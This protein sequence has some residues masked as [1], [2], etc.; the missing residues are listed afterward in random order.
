MHQGG[1]GNSAHNGP[2]FVSWHRYYLV[3]FE[4]ALREK[5]SR[6][7]L[8][9]W[10]ST[11]DYLMDNQKDSILFTEIFLGNPKG[12][13]YSGP[14]A[15]WE[16]PTIPSTLL[17]RD[18]GRFGSPIDPQRLETVFSKKY[19]REIL[20]K[21]TPDSSYANLESHHDN[22]HG[23][24]G[25]DDGHMSDV[26]LS[27][28]D[29]VFWLHH[30]FVDYLW[31]KFRKRQKILGINSE[32]DYP[33]TTIPEHKPNRLM[34]N[35]RPSKKNIQ[36][37]SNSFTK[38]IYR[39][40]PAPTCR[41]NCGGAFKGFLLCDRS[42]K[43]CVSGSRYDFIRNGGLSRVKSFY[44]SKAKGKRMDIPLS[45]KNIKSSDQPTMV[46]DSIKAEGGLPDIK[47][48][49]ISP[50]ERTENSQLTRTST[51][52]TITQR[53]KMHFGSGRSRS[54]RSAEFS[55]TGN[56]L[57]IGFD[58]NL[59]LRQENRTPYQ[60]DNLA[61][62]PIAITNKHEINRK[63]GHDQIKN[64]RT[65]N[66]T[67]QT[68][69]F[70]YNGRHLDYISIDERTRFSESIGLIV[71]KKPVSD[72]TKT[73]V[74]AYDSNGEMCQPSCLVSKSTYKEC[75]GLLKITSDFPRMYVD[76]Y[77]DTF[78]SEITPFLRF[79]CVN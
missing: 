62:S 57:N 72:E 52:P 5:N 35:L 50:F 33:P 43:G 7:T 64:Q 74:R 39:Y 76:S 79:V 10:D 61:M 8:P 34:D 15:F 14:F 17:R 9:Y 68:D 75:S 42:K 69:G 78:D 30:C 23:W 4:N 58:I 73:Y 36:G 66:I 28:M 48:G 3:L 27:P 22:V 44:P 41:N 18:V 67:F 63:P 77:N 51:A 46:S 38:Q 25:G 71:F 12:V 53:F 40:A 19:H 60:F 31:E 55:L 26:N 49:S 32:T 1:A 24:V 45:F 29:P 21:T 70:S 2:N 11:A 56:N 6:V 47:S 37:Y 65:F 59:R 16:T 54:R 20:R 13:V